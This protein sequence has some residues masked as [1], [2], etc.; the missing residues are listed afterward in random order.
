MIFTH[1]ESAQQFNITGGTAGVL[2]PPG[3]HR[4]FSLA[5]VASQGRYPEQG[6][7]VNDICTESIFVQA[8]T[9]DIT[10]NGQQYTLL[11]GDMLS[12][13]PGEQ[14]SIEGSAQ[15]LDIITPAW[16]STQNHIIQ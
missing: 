7:S 1:R 13:E 6:F 8:G 5:V 14:Y 10:V 11:P 15:C 9:L 2:Y 16:D 3:P 12:I 4:S